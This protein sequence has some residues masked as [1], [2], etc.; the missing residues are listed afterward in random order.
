MN[1]QQYRAHQES[2]RTTHLDFIQLREVIPQVT[3]RTARIDCIVPEH[4]KRVGVRGL[5][6]VLDILN[7][8][9]HT[10]PKES[11]TALHM[12]FEKG[13]GDDINK[14]TRPIKILLAL[15]RLRANVLN[16]HLQG[17][18]SPEDFANRQFAPYKGAS[19]VGLRRL[20][21]TLLHVGLNQGRASVVFLDIAAAFDEV[22]QSVTQTVADR[23]PR[24]VGEVTGELLQFYK[25]LRTHVVTVF[26][27]S[28]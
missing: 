13:A 14:H 17:I 5:R 28:A 8:P 3:N 10:W 7:Q 16:R 15:L 6:R 26:G 19:T 4:I 20:L 25:D 12:V 18:P 24:G 2:T 23:L 1:T 9:M 11:K 21:H 22:V 27:L